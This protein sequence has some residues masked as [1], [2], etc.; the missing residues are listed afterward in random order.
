MS[1]MNYPKID[2]EVWVIL[3]ACSKA[4]SRGSNIF[5]ISLNRNHVVR[6]NKYH[7]KG[8]NR[9]RLS[10][11]LKWCIDNE[12]LVFYKGYNYDFDD[13]G[14]FQNFSA[15]ICRLIINMGV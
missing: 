14:Y 3:S 10:S 13:N 11:A 15:G 7:K 5:S 9:D 6:A 1:N 12:Y 4:I 8:I 2:K